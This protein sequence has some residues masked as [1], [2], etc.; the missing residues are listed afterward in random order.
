MQ[1]ADVT[2]VQCFVCW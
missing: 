2:D 1:F